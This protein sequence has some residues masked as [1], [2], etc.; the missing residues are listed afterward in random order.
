MP[1]LAATSRNMP[2]EVDWVRVHSFQL[3]VPPTPSS[4]SLAKGDLLLAEVQGPVAPATRMSCKL[5]LG[6][7]T[8]ARQASDCRLLEGSDNF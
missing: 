6:S 7:E 4:T 3:V 8:L 1:W 2:R 5:L